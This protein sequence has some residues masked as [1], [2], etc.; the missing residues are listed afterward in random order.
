MLVI[1]FV[2]KIYVRT[3]RRGIDKFVQKWMNN[4][5]EKKYERYLKQP[6]KCN[7]YKE[8]IQVIVSL[9]SF[10]ERIKTVHLVIES[11]LMQTVQPDKIILCLCESEFPNNYCIPHNLEKL[12]SDRFEI[13][14]VEENLMPHMKYFYTMQ[15]Y[16]EAIIITV[17]DDGF[18]RKKLIK[19]LLSSYEKFPDAVSCLRSHRIKFDNNGKIYPYNKWVHESIQFNCPSHYLLATGVGGVLYPPHCLDV[20]AFDKEQIVK[21][22]LKA[23]DLWLKIMELL[24]GTKVVNV[25]TLYKYVIA[26]DYAESEVNLMTDN[27]HNNRNDIYLKQL[28]DV[29]KISE[30]NFV[31]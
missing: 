1:G 14:W 27:V 7:I 18:Y 17:D 13:M 5:F 19:K 23:D 21:L 24:K 16:P 20:R 22:C 4:N 28:M 3:L 11:L 2:R 26:I 31:E 8:N 15:K 10:P 30:E 12:V 25:P 29:Y 9:T 6:K